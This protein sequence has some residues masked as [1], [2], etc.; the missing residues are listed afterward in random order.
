[1]THSR[2]FRVLF[3]G[4]TA[5]AIIRP[6]YSFAQADDGTAEKPKPVRTI[7]TGHEKS[8]AGFKMALSRDGKILAT[9]G[10]EGVQV[11]NTE[12]WQRLHRIE[13]VWP[14]I[15]LS[16]DGQT[17]V[18]GVWTKDRNSGSIEIWSVEKGERLE[19]INAHR[20]SGG[21]PYMHH[22]RAAFTPDGKLLVTAG[23]LDGILSI[24]QTDSWTQSRALGSAVYPWSLAVSP[25]GSLLAVSEGKN[26]E[27]LSLCVWH[28]MSGRK[29]QTIKGLDALNPAPTFSSDGRMLAGGS[30]DGKVRIWDAR[31]GEAKSMLQGAAKEIG[32]GSVRSLYQEIR[33]VAFSPDDKLIAGGDSAG[34][35]T[36]WDSVSGEVRRKFKYNSVLRPDDVLFCDT[37]VLVFMPDGKSLL[38]GHQNGTINVWSLEDG[39]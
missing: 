23:A 4:W 16:P 35:V 1:M 6:N 39:N 34:G 30:S 32:R 38:S 19:T 5:L 25:D 28:L 20:G 22:T 8:P 14:L 33:C 2:T 36:L 10:H 21:H 18:A 17:L 3:V 29:L 15:A 27:T 24:W 12:T 13:P 7:D 11:W 31:T 26:L 9:G 37:R